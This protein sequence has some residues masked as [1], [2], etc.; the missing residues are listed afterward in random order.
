MQISQ[1]SAAVDAKLRQLD[2][3]LDDLNCQQ[4]QAG[5]EAQATLARDIAALQQVRRKLV[6]SR[7]LAVRAHQLEQD[8][9]SVA[10]EQA[11]ARQRL[12]GLSLCAISLLGGIAL[13][14]YV[15]VNL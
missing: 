1:V 12:L 15:V 2:R 7:D 6:K 14:A 11:R 13:I 4:Q 10:K 8:T 3:Q 5:I 9:N